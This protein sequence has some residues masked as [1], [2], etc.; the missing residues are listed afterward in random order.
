MPSTNGHGSE[1][2]R[3]ALYLRV[4]S[5]EQRDRETIEIQRD[6]L[7][8]YRSLM[9]LEVADVYED[10]GISGTIP[11]H[12][13]PEG[14][15]LLE[16]AKEG[17]FGAVLVYK[18]DRLGRS[19]LVIVDAHDRL[20]TS[21]AS[22]RSATEPIDTSNP[23]GR[24]IF[25][26]LASFAEYE[27]GTIRERTQAGLHRALRNGKFSGRI[28]YGYRRSPDETSLTLVEEEAQ[29]VREIIANIAAGATLYSES[30]RLN[31]EG[32]P[33]PG[34]RFRG[35]E[36]RRDTRSWTASTV[37]GIVQQAAYSGLHRVRIEGRGG[38]EE[39]IER[40]VPAIVEPSL[41]ERAEAQLVKNK[42]RAGELRKNGRKYLL[43]GLVRCGICGQA[44]SGRTSTAQV[45]DGTKKYAYYRCISNRR[46]RR[47]SKAGEGGP[48]HRVPNIHAD[49]LEGLVWADVRA[50]LANP[51]EV[52]ERV[53]EH[54]ADE[55]D[56]AEL[57][58]RCGSLKKRLAEVQAELNRLLNLYATGEIDAGWLTTHVRDREG[59]IDN[60][61]LLIASVES[62]IASR[63][64]NRLAAEQTK[65]WLRR[66]ADNLAEVEGDSIEA[67]ARRRE[68]V[69]LLV[70][71]ITADRDDDGRP[72]VHMTYRFGPPP[73]DAFVQSV[74]NS[75]PREAAKIFRSAL[76]PPP[77]GTRKFGWA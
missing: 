27:R 21:R 30:K 24:L 41:R 5:E 34:Y 1:P 12:E 64:Q 19:L 62:D 25:Q 32:V 73:K 13:R 35:D 36:R 71:K 50:F 8:Q 63:E 4:S 37:G 65:T 10:D 76:S 44:C 52:L 68:L 67:F 17:K 6:F 15:R 49:W 59:Q 77:L 55:D 3:V 16:D 40:P 56:Y 66:L 22:L 18:L 11:L 28:P 45:S 26:M 38:Q 70:E 72:R 29:I 42:S 69:Q 57:D 39:I 58:E 9:E 61:K 33:S 14:R 7:E 23:S 43:S 51:G 74:R 20:E 54:M 75:G 47:S 46:E 48:P 53:R 60:L 31:D 2:E